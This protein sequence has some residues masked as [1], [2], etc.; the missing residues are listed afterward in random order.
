MH[1]CDI[2]VSDGLECET[3]SQPKQPGPVYDHRRAPNWVKTSRYV[4]MC[5]NETARGLS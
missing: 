4:E 3:D 1:L 2:L 5:P